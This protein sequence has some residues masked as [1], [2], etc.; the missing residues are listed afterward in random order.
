MSVFVTNVASMIGIGVAV[1]YSLFVLARYREE[2]QGG[3]TPADARRI[4]MRTSGLAVAFS[5]VTVMLSLAGL[6]LV[7]STTIRSMAMGAI[8]VVAVS[9][10]AAVTLLPALMRLLGHRAYARGRRGRHRRAR[11]G[12]TCAAAAGAPGRAIPRSRV[13]RSGSAGPRPSPAA[14][15]WPPRPAPRILLV[16]AIPALSL[17]WGDGALRQFPKGNETRVGAEI[18]AS[19]SSPGAVRADAGG[20]LLRRRPGR[21]ARAGGLLRA[22]PPRPRG[23]VGGQAGDRERRALGARGR[24]PAPRSREP[25]GTRSARPPA[26]AAGRAGRAR[27]GRRHD[28][29][30]RGLQ[31]P[32]LRLALEDRAVRDGAVVLRAADPAALG[33]P[34]AQGGA[35]EPAVGRRRVRRAGRRLP[36]GL[37]RRRSPAT[38]RS[39]TST[40]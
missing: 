6:F 33:R 15:S 20:R 12:A 26:R 2:V 25:G 16:L 24:D 13:R 27:A 38:S 22:G 17:K 3:A 7:D 36:V 28:R 23:P 9:V 31:G 1:D 14:R 34:A 30:R 8:V 18:A 32:R 39:A 5:G 10:L 19:A 4:A 37:A 35:D 40:R 21:R 29:A 11:C